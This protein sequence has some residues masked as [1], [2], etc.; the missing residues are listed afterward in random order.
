[1]GRA[2]SVLDSGKNT[3]QVRAVTHLARESIGLI[4]LPYAKTKKRGRPQ[5]QPSHKNSL[6]YV[7]QLTV[8]DLMQKHGGFFT[9]AK[10]KK[11]RADYDFFPSKYS[12]TF[13]DSRMHGKLPRP[14]PSRR[15]QDQRHIDEFCIKAHRNAE[16][17]RDITA[18][19]RE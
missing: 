2:F 6:L 12:A 18:H 8:P 14:P 3:R 13:A 9:T 10:T 11:W 1:M 4:L 15:M 16:T 7:T 5:E 17:R 19:C